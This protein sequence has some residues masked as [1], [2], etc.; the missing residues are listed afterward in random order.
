[1]LKAPHYCILNRHNF[2]SLQQ[3]TASTPSLILVAPGTLGSLSWTIFFSN[4]PVKYNQEI[5]ACEQCQYS[6]KKARNIP[7]REFCHSVPN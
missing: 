7:N 3:G 5:A 1:L 4:L 6:F 2:L